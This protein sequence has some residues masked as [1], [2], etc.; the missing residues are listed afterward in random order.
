TGVHEEPAIVAERVAV[1][2]LNGAADRRADVG[3]EVRRADVVRELVQ[4]VVVPGRL[5]AVEDARRGRV[6]VP[7]DT[8][9]VAVRGF[10]AKPRVEALVNQRVSRGIERFFEED[11]RSRVCEPTAHG[12]LLS[13]VWCLVAAVT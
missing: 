2:L 13:V 1:R 8:E 5:G 11:R 10:G 6:A 3:E 7:A 9:A 4:V 12:P